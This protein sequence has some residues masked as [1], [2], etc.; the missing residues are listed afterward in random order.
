MTENLN[1]LEL[2]DRYLNN[3]MNEEELRNFQQQIDTDESL[4]RELELF[5]K[6]YSG[7]ETLAKEKLKKKLNNYY[8]QYTQTEKKNPQALQRTLLIWGS[9][10]ATLLICAILFFTSNTNSPKSNQT[11]KENKTKNIDTLKEEIKTKRPLAKNRNQKKSENKERANQAYGGQNSPH[12]SM[13]GINKLPKEYIRFAK[14]PS[15]LEYVFDGKQIILYGDPLIPALQLQVLKT[16]DSKYIL[17]YKNL[18][19]PI[20]ITR[21]KIRLEESTIN[22]N[23]GTITDE[24]IAVKLEGIDAISIPDDLLQVTLSYEKVVPP[25]YFFQDTSNIFQL[26]LEGDFSIEKVK[27][28]R[29][30]MALGISYVME[31]NDRLF[32][33][34]H[35]KQ[36]PSPLEEVPY[37]KNN[38][39]RLFAKREI[40]IKDVRS[41]D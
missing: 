41:I 8:Q 33:L 29:I 9:M 23:I 7:I 24:Q 14:Y 35:A 2:I 36:E 13:G 38:L 25:S 20:L 39:T 40:V 32:V 19:Y 27:I 21:S 31:Y 37:L 1:H 16:R 18:F 10:A 22:Y 6:I 30:E 11:T 15:A 4:K 5:Q 26:I 12:L 17:A 28:Y 34:D 3:E